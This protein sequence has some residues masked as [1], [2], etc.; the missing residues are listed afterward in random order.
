MNLI[1]R[2]LD[3]LTQSRLFE[4]RDR[5][6]LDLFPNDADE[7]PIFVH[8]CVK[9]DVSKQLTHYLSRKSRE[10][11]DTLCGRCKR[12]IKEQFHSVGK[13][14]DWSKLPGHHK[15]IFWDLFPDP[16]HFEPELED[17]P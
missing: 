9:C 11:F 4:L 12:P 6:Y 10:D 7:Y 5:Q 3:I 1:D 17:T 14:L 16:F 2:S 15:V 8:D 13:R